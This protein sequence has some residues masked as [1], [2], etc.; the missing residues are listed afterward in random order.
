M[1]C[2]GGCSLAHAHPVCCGGSRWWKQVLLW[3]GR[4]PVTSTRAFSRQPGTTRETWISTGSWRG[5]GLYSA[6][7]NSREL[8]RARGS[9]TFFPMA[10]ENFCFSLFMQGKTT[11]WQYPPQATHFRIG[12]GS[13][14]SRPRSPG[15]WTWPSAR[16]PTI[17]WWWGR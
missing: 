6:Y 9:M 13:T 4:W 14:Q 12:V 3:S 17:I 1:C 10:V 5:E 11:L 8:L 15:L 16:G 2:A 7:S